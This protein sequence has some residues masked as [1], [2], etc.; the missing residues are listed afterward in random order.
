MQNL[1]RITFVICCALLVIQQ[2]ATA[3]LVSISTWN[4][5][6]FPGRF[7]VWRAEI[8][9]AALGCL[10]SAS[11]MLRAAPSALRASSRRAASTDREGP[12]DVDIGDIDVPVLLRGERCTEPVPFSERFGFQQ[13]SSPAPLARYQRGSPLR[14]RVCSWLPAIALQRTVVCRRSHPS[15]SALPV[16]SL[17]CRSVR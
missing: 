11:V 8:L 14:C 12:G 17:S 3:E 4:L 1:R 5:E 2:G 15:P 16:I 10:A 6:W 7:P 9:P 13:S